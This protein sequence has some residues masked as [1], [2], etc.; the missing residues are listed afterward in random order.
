MGLISFSVLLLISLSWNAISSEAFAKTT[1]LTN[2]NLLILSSYI[3]KFITIIRT[4]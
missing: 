1:P 4:P 3:T 2:K